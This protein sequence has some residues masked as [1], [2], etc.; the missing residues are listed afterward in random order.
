MTIL[1]ASGN[2]AAGTEVALNTPVAGA[3]D[4]AIN[5]T[6]RFY[7][8]FTMP[9]A[10]NFYLVTGFEVL[11]GTVINGSF[12][13]GLE[14]INANPPTDDGSVLRA[15]CKGQTQTGASA[16]QRVSIVGSQLIKGGTLVG[17]FIS[18]NSATG[19]YGTTTQAGANRLKA[20]V[21]NTDVQNGNTTAWASGTE[22]PYIKVYGKPVF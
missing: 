4:T 9:T 7:T 14:E 3:N 1:G 12:V 22:E 20:L 15:W 18:S 17:A 6:N 16:V 19:R 13:C 8:M 2:F 5:T 11:N 10:A 21:Y